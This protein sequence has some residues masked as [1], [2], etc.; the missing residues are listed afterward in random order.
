MFWWNFVSALILLVKFI[1]ATFI[2]TSG[3]D[4]IQKHFYNVDWNAS[5]NRRYNQS[6]KPTNFHEMRSTI[7]IIL[8]KWQSEYERIYKK[9]NKQ[10]F[11]FI[12]KETFLK[13]SHHAV[14]NGIKLKSLSR[15]QIWKANKKLLLKNTLGNSKEVTPFL[16]SVDVSLFIW[17]FKIEFILLMK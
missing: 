14:K 2:H 16:E 13:Y 4:G 8:C 12:N 5:Y 9:Y 7:S 10:M 11:K 15:I 3:Q 1:S 6:T 17:L